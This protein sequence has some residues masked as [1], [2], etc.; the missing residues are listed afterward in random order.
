MKGGSTLSVNS[1][2]MTTNLGPSAVVVQ[3]G[4]TF[5]AYGVSGTYIPNEFFMI[6]NNSASSF[7]VQS[8]FSAREGGH[9]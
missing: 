2:L 6:Q 4:G 7:V 3:S 1:I 8:P 5:R 9:S